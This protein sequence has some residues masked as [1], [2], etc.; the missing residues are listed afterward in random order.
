MLSE[1]VDGTRLAYEDYGQGEPILFLA[2]W[3]LHSDMWEYQLPFFVEHG[4]RC[5]ALD[6]RGHGR[7][8]RAP[9][10][11]TWTPWRTTWPR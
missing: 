7:S 11:T 2:S 10:A 8:D 5:V 6:R 1:T 9:P 3:V 4:Y